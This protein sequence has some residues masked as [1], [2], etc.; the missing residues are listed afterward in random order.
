MKYHPE[1]APVLTDEQHPIGT[2]FIGQFDWG[3]LLPKRNGGAPWYPRPGRQSGN[4]RRKSTRVPDC[5]S[6]RSSRDE[7]RL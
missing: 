1:M 5:E 3:G 7:S 2:V 4:A 6:D